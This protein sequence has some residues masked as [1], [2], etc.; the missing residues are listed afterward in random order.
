M[1]GSSRPSGEKAK[2]AIFKGHKCVILEGHQQHLPK[3]VAKPTTSIGIHE[4]LPG[5]TSRGGKGGVLGRLLGRRCRTL[6][7]PASLATLRRGPGSAPVAQSPRIPARESGH[8]KPPGPS[9]PGGSFHQLRSARDSN[10]Q[11]LSGARFR[12]E[13]NTIL[14]ALQNGSAPTM[15]GV[16]PPER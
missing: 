13:C 3:Y 11:A 12:G 10:P 16:L 9:E 14:P 8:K 5:R 4:V 1:A 15:L 7:S 6:P 2:C